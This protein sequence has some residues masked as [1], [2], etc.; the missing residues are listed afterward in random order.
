MNS[1][2][3]KLLEHAQQVISEKYPGIQLESPVQGWAYLS[4]FQKGIE[5]YRSLRS[6][7]AKDDRWLGVCLFQRFEDMLAQEAFYRALSKGE[8]AA[9]VNLAHLLRFVER[10]EEA[11]AELLKVDVNKLSPYDTVLY[12]RV[13]SLHEEMNGNIRKAVEFAEKAWALVQEIPEFQIQ[14]PSVL[15][16][17]GILYGRTGEAR[18]ALSFL[19]HGIQLTLGIEQ[20][21]VRLRR[22][23]LLVNLG[24]LDD[25]KGEL[26]L[27]GGDLPDGLEIERTF[28]SGEM[29]WAAGNLPEAVATLSEVVETAS[30]LASADEFLARLSIAAIKSHTGELTDAEE[31]LSRARILISDRIDVHSHQFREILVQ[32]ASGQSGPNEAS[33]GLEMLAIEFHRLGTLQEEASVRLHLASLYHRA[34]DARAIS[35]LES[36]ARICKA[37]RN[38]Q[39]LRKEWALLPDLRAFAEANSPS[40]FAEVRSHLRVNSIGSECLFLD[41]K[42]VRTPLRRT[43]ELLAY[44]LEHREVTLAQILRDLFPDKKSRSARSYFHQFRFQLRKLI[45]GL[46]V[47][48]DPRL[49]LYSLSGEVDIDW[50]VSELRRGET[51]AVRGRFLASSELPWAKSLDEDIQALIAR[52][53]PAH[54]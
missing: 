35:E 19:D 31:H 44:F 3:L 7:H 16:Q 54:E 45:Q 14:A 34:G 1:D 36:V 8:E 15:G 40:L 30:R 33:S 53:P 49:N 10:S 12:L 38:N 29:S 17:L 51:P 13:S 18:K 52:H 26:S 50:D 24:R 25:A 9:R 46:E 32:V 42:Q 43:V 37:V 11:V 4:E 48:F 47:V 27:L 5:V 41:G 28:L 21:K 6:P 23:T 22:A 20:Q 39:F 2:D